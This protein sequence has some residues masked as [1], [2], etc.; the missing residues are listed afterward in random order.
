MTK[1]MPMRRI[2]MLSC[3]LL[4]AACGS[5]PAA[6]QPS[7]EPAAANTA[8]A[9]A[10]PAD[11]TKQPG[12]PFQKTTGWYAQIESS[13]FSV[14]GQV[15]FMMAG[16]K[17]AL[18]KRPS[19]APGTI[20]LDLSLAAAPGGAV[21]PAAH[22]EEPLSRAYSRVAIFCGGEEVTS[23]EPMDQRLD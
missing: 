9:E 19:A 17:P 21:E 14:D 11:I 4:L 20:A 23:F 8:A 3:L 2:S 18:T 7:D 1:G 5:E 22:Y 10:Q 15:D 16:Y 13:R 6:Q 12:C